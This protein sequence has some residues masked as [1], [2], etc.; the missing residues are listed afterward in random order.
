MMRLP[1]QLIKEQ[2]MSN[3]EPLR[4]FIQDMTR[5]VGKYGDDEP[6]MLREEKSCSPA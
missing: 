4:R 2:T 3:I 6:A 5:A 1:V